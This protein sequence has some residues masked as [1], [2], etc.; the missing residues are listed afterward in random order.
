MPLLGDVAIVFFCQKIRL[1]P[2]DQNG[3]TVRQHT[4]FPDGLCRVVEDVE[5]TFSSG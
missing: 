1:R 4:A 3:E 5:V 2:E